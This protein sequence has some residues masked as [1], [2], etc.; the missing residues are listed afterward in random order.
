MTDT[1]S[2]LH[3]RGPSAASLQMCL[4]SKCKIHNIFRKK[5]LFLISNG[6]NI[7]KK[8]EEMCHRFLGK[9]E[10]VPACAFIRCC[11]SCRIL[12][13]VFALPNH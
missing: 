3:V 7:K 8:C 9:E 12:E 5:N 13:N 11:H 6:A 2:L 10:L 4:C 1:A